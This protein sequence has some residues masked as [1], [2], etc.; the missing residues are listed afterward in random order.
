MRGRIQ[1]EGERTPS[2]RSD[3]ASEEVTGDDQPLTTEQ[4]GDVML[5]FAERDVA[6][7]DGAAKA[8][9]AATRRLARQTDRLFDPRVADRASARGRDSDPVRTYLRGMATVSL[10][11]RDGEIALAS[12]LEEAVLDARLTALA[13]W[14]G[15]DALLR[16]DPESGA[17]RA[18]LVMDSLDEKRCGELADLCSEL[19]SLAALRS[20][21]ERELEETTGPAELDEA[22]ARLDEVREKLFLTNRELRLGVGQF[23]RIAQAVHGL[24]A[25]A[26]DALRRLERH[27]KAAGIGVP[28]LLTSLRRLR[29]AGRTGRRGGQALAAEYQELE[30]RTAATV[31]TLVGIER[32]SQ[33]PIDELIRVD[34]EIQRAES[35]A[36]ASRSALVQANLRLVVSIAK[37]YL[38][39]GLPFLDLIQEGN[40]GLMRAVDKFE[41][42]RGYK[43]STYAHWWIRQAITR[44]IADQSRTIRVPVHMTENINRLNRTSR[45][46]VQKLGREPTLEEIAS[47]LELP[48]SKVRLTLRSAKQPISLETPL[49]AEDDFRLGDIIEDQ[50]NIS[51]TDAVEVRDLRRHTHMVLATLTPRE[52]CILRMR[53]G[54]GEQGTATLEEVGQKFHVTRE[55]IRQ[56]EAKALAKLRHPALSNRLAAFW[57]D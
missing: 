48:V 19:A 4:L 27:A 41:Y 18:D 21:R 14:P 15:I 44:A 23:L 32:A 34:R 51:Q 12:D 28:E 40:M 11:S 42:R 20:Q 55:R 17:H 36:A 56:I 3:E 47:E 24:A 31:S 38:N 6:V 16:L 57:E 50:T 35:A 7:A 26:E 37:K 1:T 22:R 52:E 2:R 9:K 49:G 45:Y 29:E 8:G 33:L 53:F 54:I 46:L 30:R 43:F 39:R 13:A 5:L 10:L 25:E